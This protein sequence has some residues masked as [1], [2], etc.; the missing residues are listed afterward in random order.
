M[1]NQESTDD[2]PPITT[3]PPA[4]NANHVTTDN[5]LL[6]VMTQ[7]QELMHM[8]ESNIG[9]RRAN[10]RRPTA[11]PSTGPRQGQP[12]TP[13]PAHFNKYCWTHGRGNHKG[14]SCNNKAPGHKDTATMTDKMGGSTYGC[15]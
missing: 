13:M 12:R 5:I 9:N 8:L 10:N 7:N 4:V 14:A 11:R 6:Q 15:N 1:M 3:P 2:P